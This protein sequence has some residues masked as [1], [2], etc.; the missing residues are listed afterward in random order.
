MSLSIHRTSLLATTLFLWSIACTKTV[1]NPAQ[2]DRD[3]YLSVVRAT[4]PDA[5]QNL[6]TCSTIQDA[7]MRSECTLLVARGQAFR[8]TDLAY[9]WCPLVDGQIWKDECYFMAAESAW[10]RRDNHGARTLC[11]SAGRFYHAC[12][13]HLYQLGRNQEVGHQGTDPVTARKRLDALISDT[14][15]RLSPED[16]LKEQGLWLA[17]VAM[18]HNIRQAGWCEPLRDDIE[19]ACRHALHSPQGLRG[20]PTSAMPNGASGNGSTPKH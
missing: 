16:Y 2:R 9:D 18:R 15:V 14:G 19:A 12:S 8:G 3:A 17:N 20:V 4:N 10:A 11:Q 7:P 13:Q 5:T 1:P 6:A